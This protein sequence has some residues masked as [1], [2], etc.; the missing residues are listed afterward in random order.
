M[1]NW[2]SAGLLNLPPNSKDAQIFEQ[3]AKQQAAMQGSP[4]A[5]P[6]QFP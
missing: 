1:V 3:F 6:G 2:Q 5:S 4:S